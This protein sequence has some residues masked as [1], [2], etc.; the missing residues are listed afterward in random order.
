MQ[1]DD[2]LVQ[3]CDHNPDCSPAEANAGREPPEAGG[4]SAQAGADEEG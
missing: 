3:H 2:Q 4:V 1:Y